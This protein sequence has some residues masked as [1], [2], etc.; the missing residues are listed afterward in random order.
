MNP[1]AVHSR[2]LRCPA[3][4]PADADVVK[5]EVLSSLARSRDADVTK[6]ESLRRPERDSPANPQDSL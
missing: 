2:P 3:T 4:Q 6:S 1:R 5:R